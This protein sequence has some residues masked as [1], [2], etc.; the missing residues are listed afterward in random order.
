MN[1][2]HLSFYLEKRGLSG[3]LDQKGLR[4]ARKK[5]AV[6]VADAKDPWRGWAMRL[7]CEVEWRL[8]LRT[9][10]ST[11]RRMHFAPQEDLDRELEK[12]YCGKW[13]KRENRKGSHTHDFLSVTCLACW[14]RIAAEAAERIASYEEIR[15]EVEE[16]QSVAS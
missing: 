1:D 13:M 2:K 14:K 4:A 12:P 15:G 7:L 6:S 10:E 8:A 3:T 5:L 16:G 9:A 11:K